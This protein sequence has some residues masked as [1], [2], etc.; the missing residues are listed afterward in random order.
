MNPQVYQLTNYKCRRPVSQ[1]K[2]TSFTDRSQS[3]C[4]RSSATQGQLNFSH[5]TAA[6]PTYD[7][8]H[9]LDQ[10]NV[11]QWLLDTALYYEKQRFGGY[12]R[13][14]IDPTADS[15]WRTSRLM[16]HALSRLNELAQL[17]ELQHVLDKQNNTED[18]LQGFLGRRNNSVVWFESRGQISSVAYLNILNNARLR[19]QFTAKQ[20]APRK[21]IF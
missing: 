18:F 1:L 3:R 4:A 9:V 20:F 15:I 14:V 6:L 5:A 10:I 16:H 13:H 11:S 21:R 8:L 2:W 12:Q 7:Q 19:G 17:S